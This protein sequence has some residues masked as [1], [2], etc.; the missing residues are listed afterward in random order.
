MP[1]RRDGMHARGLDVG[2]RRLTPRQ[3]TENSERAR[4]CS[5]AVETLQHVYLRC[6]HYTAARAV[7]VAAMDIWCA[8]MRTRDELDGVY[9]HDDALRLIH[10]DEGAPDPGWCPAHGALWRAAWEFWQGTR[11]HK[12]VLGETDDA[13]TP[14]PNSPGQALGPSSHTPIWAITARKRKKI[15]L[16]VLVPTGACARP[17]RE[18]RRVSWVEP[19]PHPAEC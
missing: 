6:P 12:E 9:S 10:S 7:L 2:W 1:L 4:T 16:L 5:A 14:L 11:Q 15:P 18:W 8:A 19:T 17:S 13:A 3:R